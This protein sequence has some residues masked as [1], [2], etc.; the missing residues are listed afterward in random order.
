LS[1]V[2]PIADKLLR[3]S[4][5]SDVPITDMGLG[6]QQTTFQKTKAAAYGQPPAEIKP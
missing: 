1:V 2:A 4:E 3:R 6:A 5:R